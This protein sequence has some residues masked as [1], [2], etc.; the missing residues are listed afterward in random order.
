MMQSKTD[1]KRAK[2]QLSQIH[3]RFHGCV[4]WLSEEM[5]VC[6]ALKRTKKRPF[7]RL[8]DELQISLLCIRGYSKCGMWVLLAFYGHMSGT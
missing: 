4:P 3:C 2:S 7:L 6:G 5:K 1:E 8:W